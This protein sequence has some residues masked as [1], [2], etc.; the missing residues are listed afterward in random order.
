MKISPEELTEKEV[1]EK[2]KTMNQEEVSYTICPKLIWTAN[3]RSLWPPPP[4]KIWNFKSH[5][6][7][8]DRVASETPRP[9]LFGEIQIW[10]GFP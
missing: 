4:P 5:V 7:N 3:L 1:K 9:P 6:K 2:E 8:L 10:L